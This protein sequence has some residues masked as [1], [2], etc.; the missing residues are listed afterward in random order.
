MGEFLRFVLDSQ[1][2]EAIRNV[3]AAI[4]R[5]RSERHCG[6][7]EDFVQS[8]DS[9]SLDTMIALAYCEGNRE[10][11]RRHKRDEDIPDDSTR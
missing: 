8:L 3:L 5:R 2:S 9:D 11:N 4:D 1:S 6:K 7:I 10:L